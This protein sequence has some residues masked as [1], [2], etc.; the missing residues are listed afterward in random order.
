M[1][2]YREGTTAKQSRLNNYS[3]GSLSAKIFFLEHT[4]DNVS[5][6]VG[7]RKHRMDSSKRGLWLLFIV[8]IY[9][10]LSICCNSTEIMMACSSLVSS[11]LNCIYYGH[12]VSK[13]PN[14]D[15]HLWI[16]KDS[17]GAGKKALCLVNTVRYN[18]TRS[19]YFHFSCW[20]CEFSLTK[21]CLCIL[22]CPSIPLICKHFL[23]SSCII[24]LKTD[25]F[26]NQSLEPSLLGFKAT[27]WKRSCLWCIG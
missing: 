25:M 3:R 10:G 1:C 6:R 2:V 13:R 21:W 27:E 15:H 16:R 5:F 17:A 12:R 22:F 19:W 14:K 20:M 7:R 26:S 4:P 23:T 24:L 18:A 9:V 8:W 11:K